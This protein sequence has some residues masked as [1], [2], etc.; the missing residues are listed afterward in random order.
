MELYNITYVSVFIDLFK[1]TIHGKS[2]DWRM[3]HFM[4]LV[5]I[6][7]P[8]I[9]FI[10]EDL[11]E[12]YKDTFIKYE[13]VKIILFKLED[14]FIYKIVYER[15]DSLEL[16]KSR[17]EEKDT[18]DFMILMNQKIDFLEKA[19]SINP[20]KTSYFSWIDFNISH[21]F[22]NTKETFKYINFCAKQIYDKSFICIPGCWEKDY[23]SKD[24]FDKIHWRFCGGY[25]LGDNKSLLYF[26]ELYR[27]HYK[28]FLDKYKKNIWEVNFWVW[29][30]N[31][32]KD[33]NI[34]W[35]KSD[36]NDSIIT[37]LP[38]T[39]FTTKLEFLNKI[40]YK[41]IIKHIEHYDPSSGSFIIYNN[42]RILNMRYVNYILD[43]NGGYYLFHSHG[44][45]LTIN[46][47]IYLDEKNM[48]ISEF[49]MKDDEISLPS[50]SK[51]YQGFEDIRLYEFNNK[52][53]FIATSYN[54]SN[55]LYKNRIFI[56][57]YN[58]EDRSYQNIQ[59]L[60]PPF[61]N[62]N[63]NEKNWI[64][65]YWKS[66]ELFIY[67]W[68]PYKIGK[69]NNQFKLE[70]ILS[71]EIQSLPQMKH[72]K[73]SS[74]PVFYKNHCYCIIHY[75]NE[76]KTENNHKYFYYHKIIELDSNTL[77]PLQ[78]SE[79][80]I[81][82]H[83]GIEYCIGFHIE[84]DHYYFWYSV[85]DAQPKMIETPMSSITFLPIKYVF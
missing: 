64:P 60:E 23:L 30:E 10:T 84:N 48:P 12:L 1:K 51:R 71:Y 28:Y 41:P 85:K 44:N 3:N 26:N 4:N 76:E 74:I 52:L 25:L 65:I 49:M 67:Q 39:L 5:I 45:N 68:Y 14:S 57:D 46:K 33:L 6:G 35:Y 66:N 7:V 72:W 27:Q 19:I 8:I 37:N 63:Q 73:G 53:R 36:H 34:I 70:I 21:I 31:K 20:W 18:H 55:I 77:L 59:L 56:G 78:H 83:I 82:D 9:L 38:N 32:F 61:E 17:N 15:D 22:K 54:F 11:Y 40:E 47:C 13:N 79:S 16:P 62:K 24:I 69:L 42:Q 80:F 43:G 58:I 50:I 75:K 2:L 29:L 81:F